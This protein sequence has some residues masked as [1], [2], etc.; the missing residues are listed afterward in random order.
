[1]LKVVIVGAG[2]IGSSIARVLSRYEN[3]E[4][5]LVDKEPDVG[6]GAS[7][8][9][10][11]IIHPGHEEDPLNHPLR[12]KLCVEGNM[13][14]RKWVSELDIPAKWPGELMLFYDSETES[15]AK[16]F[17][18]W[19]KANGVE[20][21]LLD[22]AELRKIEPA[23]SDVAKGAV[24]APSAGVISPMEAVIGIVENAVENSVKL[25][26]ETYV[27]RVVARNGEV[28]GVETDRG[29]IEANVVIN[30]AGVHAD[31]IARTAGVDEW[32]KIKPR[33][34]EYLLFDEKVPVKPLHILHT[35]PTPVTK[36]VY[37][38]TTTHNTLLIGPTAEDLDEEMKEYLGNT[39]Y[40][41]SYLWSQ[42]PL[43]LREPPPRNKLIRYFSGIRPEPPDGQ[44]LIK[45]YDN[46]RG[47][48]NV[49]GIRSPGLTAAPA[50]AEYVAKLLAEAVDMKL[51]EKK[52]WIP[53]RRSIPRISE[54]TL[55]EIDNLIK[56][57][58]RY[59]E[60]VCKCRLVSRAEVE[61]AIARMIKI[62]VK[63][64]TVDGVKFR[65]LAGFGQCQGSFCRQ[66]VA[67][68]ISAK[69]GIPLCKVV[70]KR[71]PYGFGGIKDLLRKVSKE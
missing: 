26:T 14:W 18:D 9:N 33:R 68:I 5:Y 25:L 24:Y 29:F 16:K 46:P 36:G 42:I 58:P 41:L 6:W 69:T 12:A 63:T 10:T 70:I 40:G 3:L 21:I 57:D 2:I 4:I 37:A 60:I 35:T 30:A 49:A 48:V 51:V 53:H 23:V 22:Q 52:K 44:W 66:R 43:L 7:K 62:G 50:I 34:G 17:I 67:Q 38:V 20:T 56:R 8:A 32:F 55:E 47:F 11:G 27:K 31:Y 13:L 39:T 64:V 59:G 28:K 61:E 45:A 71:G 65:T 1:M 19:G 15:T 54:K